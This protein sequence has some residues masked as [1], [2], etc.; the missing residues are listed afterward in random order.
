MTK[1]ELIT[2]LNNEENTIPEEVLQAMCRMIE[3]ATMLVNFSEKLE[4]TWKGWQTCEPKYV[5]LRVRATKRFQDLTRREPL[6]SLAH[7]LKILHTDTSIESGA[8]FWLPEGPVEAIKI[9]KEQW[10]VGIRDDD[11]VKE[12]TQIICAAPEPTPEP[13]SQEV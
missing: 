12:E 2:F 1:E 4:P 3:R 9:S 5:L 6:P 13:E 7:V 8:I 10:F 11:T